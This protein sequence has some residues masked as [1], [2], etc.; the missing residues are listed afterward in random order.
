M[1]R[2]PLRSIA[3][4]A[5][6]AAM[7][8]VTSYFLQ[9]ITFMSV[10]FRV[11]EALTML[12][13]IMTEGVYGVII[14]CLLTNLLSPYGIYDIVFG[15]LATAIAAVLTY[16]IKNKW[17]A[18]LPPVLVN[19]AILPLLWYFMGSENMYIVDLASIL[20]SQSVIVYVL[21]VPL[22]TLLAKRAPALVTNPRFL[23]RPDFKR[24][25][26]KN[27]ENTCNTAVNTPD[28]KDITPDAKN[29]NAADNQNDSTCD[30]RNGIDKIE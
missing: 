22:V 28:A 4:S 29:F 23:T 5:V 15:T 7:Y 17:K 12:P 16:F 20:L 27:G 1:K 30:S 8:F 18:A 2:F 6:I 13:F 3:R 26:E 14:G 25:T 11:A 21:G 19:A 9:P 24:A 10:Q